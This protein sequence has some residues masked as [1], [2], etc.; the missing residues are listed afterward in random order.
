MIIPAAIA[1]TLLFVAM[2]GFQAALAAGAPL[3]SHVLG[4]R[5]AGTLP[6]RLRLASGIAAFLLLGF[7]VIV[8]ARAGAVPTPAGLAEVLRLACWIVTA[9]LVLNTLANLA[10]KS[11]IERTLFAGIT[12]LLAVLA[13]AIALAG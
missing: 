11:P 9:F 12:A 7:A 1:A 6:A 10:S 3:G 8:L 5:N 2:A 4:G 13:G